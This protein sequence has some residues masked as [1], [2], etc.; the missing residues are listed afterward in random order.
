[1]KRA[2]DGEEIG[3][4]NAE[5]M[6]LLTEVEALKARI[7]SKQET[8]DNLTSQVARLQAHAVIADETSKISAAGGAGGLR[9]GSG[10]G[11]ATIDCDLTALVTKY[12]HEIQVRVIFNTVTNHYSLKIK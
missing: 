5:N 1:M 7:K 12:L 11:G 3:D 6:M 4:V 9:S 10:T 8:I 2:P